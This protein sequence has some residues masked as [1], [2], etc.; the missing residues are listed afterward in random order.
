FGIML[1]REFHEHFGLRRH[2]AIYD[3]SDSVRAVKHALEA[4]GYSPKSF[5]PR[6]ILSIIARAQGS[7]LDRAA[8]AESAGSFPERVAAEVWARYDTKLREEH[9]VDFDEILLLTYMLLRDHE[10]ARRFA[11]ERWTHIH[12]DEYQDTNTVQFEIA[13]LLAGDRANLCVV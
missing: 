9:A 12:V 2:F 3:R 5:E 10:P 1:L 13:R 11:R 4:A 8:F 6:R 7:A